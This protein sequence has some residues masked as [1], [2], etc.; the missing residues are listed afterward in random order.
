MI[1]ESI[2]F[3]AREL[4]VYLKNVFKMTEDAVVV[5]SVTDFSG[6]IPVKNQ[7]KIVITLINIKEETSLRNTPS[8]KIIDKTSVSV[9][10]ALYINLFILFSANFSE[11]NESLKFI[12]STIAYFQGNSVFTKERYPK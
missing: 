7:N 12:S 9:N 8:F 4:N 5:S 11:Y 1:E 3:L 10:P 2:Q 6:H